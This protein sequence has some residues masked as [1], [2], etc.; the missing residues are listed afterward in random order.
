MIAS[1]LRSISSFVKVQYWEW[2]ECL[3]LKR[4]VVGWEA[5]SWGV[6]MFMPYLM[7]K[8]TSCALW[9][10][11]VWSLLLFLGCMSLFLFFFFFFFFPDKEAFYASI[12]FLS[13]MVFVYFEGVGTLGSG[14][15]S[16][17][18]DSLAAH[19]P[20]CCWS[21]SPPFRLS[22]LLSLEG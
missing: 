11:V 15:W 19:S 12:I 2:F 13:S 18:G 3:F 14:T 21:S 7:Q 22:F 8:V 6:S 4:L 9:S 1:I 10:F 16:H 17:L 20:S 5:P